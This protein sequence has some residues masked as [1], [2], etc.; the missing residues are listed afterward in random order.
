MKRV[1]KFL[2]ALILCLTPI[3]SYAF[4]SGPGQR[5]VGLRAQGS[6][7][8]PQWVAEMKADNITFR[9]ASDGTVVT[10]SKADILASIPAGRW[11]IPA[12]MLAAMPAYSNAHLYFIYGAGASPKISGAVSTTDADTGPALPAG[13]THYAYAYTVRIDPSGQM[14]IQLEVVGN[15]V[16]FKGFPYQTVCDWY[17]PGTCPTSPTTIQI[18]PWVPDNALQSCTWY[19]PEASGKAGTGQGNLGF[20]LLQQA[21]FQIYTQPGQ[22]TTAQ[23]VACSPT[24]PGMTIAWQF[25]DGS[26]YGHYTALFLGYQILSYVIPNGG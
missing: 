18:W 16:F 11:G 8:V 6:A 7:D 24:N 10:A 21:P 25:Y 17:V 3:A 4:D 26:G 20:V 15:T 1:A 23:I 5:V 2:A 19:D 9:N 12:G 13:Y 22:V 14:P